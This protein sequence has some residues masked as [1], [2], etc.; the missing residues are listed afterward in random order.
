MAELAD[1]DGGQGIVVDL[2]GKVIDGTFMGDNLAN[3]I[4]AKIGRARGW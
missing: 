2:M 4:W 3:S 1:G